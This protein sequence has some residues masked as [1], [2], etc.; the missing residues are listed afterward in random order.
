M[1]K[2]YKKPTLN[3]FREAL[4]K[5]GGNLTETA[6]LIGV[7]RPTI[8][9]WAKEDE[10]FASAIDDTRKQLLDSCIATSRL[11]ALG[12]PIVDEK[13][14]FR[15]W[16]VPPDSNMLRYLMGTLGQNEGFGESLQLHHTVDEGI[17]ISKWIEKEIEEKRK[18]KGEQ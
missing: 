1:A 12:V 9:L 14:K 4:E 3:K 13:G 15:G 16:E 5:T 2:K 8:W 7:T 18:A 10:L 6:K 11:V 17:D